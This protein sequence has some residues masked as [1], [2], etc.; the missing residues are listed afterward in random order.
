MVL[1]LLTSKLNKDEHPRLTSAVVS[2]PSCVC[3][4]VSQEIR[5]DRVASVSLL[6]RWVGL[7][8]LQIRLKHSMDLSCGASCPFLASTKAAV[9]A[10]TQSTEK[11]KTVSQPP[12]YDW[13]AQALLPDTYTLKL[14]KL[15]TTSSAPT[16]ITWLLYKWS[17]PFH[18]IETAIW[19]VSIS[20]FCSPAVVAQR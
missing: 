11:T 18:M 20:V 13:F 17:L 4:C 9:P 6:S 2:T 5:S 10:A 12:E 8:D 14:Q 16:S 1:L 15:C 3:V 19:R 7:H